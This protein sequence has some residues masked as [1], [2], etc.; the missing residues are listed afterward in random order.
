[1]RERESLQSSANMSEGLDCSQPSI[2]EYFYSILCLACFARL[3]IPNLAYCMLA[4]LV[5]FFAL[6]NREAMNSLRGLVARLAVVSLLLPALSNTPPTGY[7]SQYSQG[8][9]Q[10]DLAINL[11]FSIIHLSE[12]SKI[13]ATRYFLCSF[14]RSSVVF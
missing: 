14:F 13:G 8:A 3:L 7:L 6:K 11:L 2:F 4:S 1:M 5:S 12:D 10:A 9:V